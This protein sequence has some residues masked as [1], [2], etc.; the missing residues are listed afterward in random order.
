MVQITIQSTTAK[1]KV[2]AFDGSAFQGK[3]FEFSVKANEKV[4]YCIEE[5]QYNISNCTTDKK[6]C[7]ALGLF[8]IP[9]NQNFTIGG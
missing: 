3:K 4:S 5:G 6:T 1:E 8:E 7:N 9:P 2:I